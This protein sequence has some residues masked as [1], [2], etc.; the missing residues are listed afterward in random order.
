MQREKE[1]RANEWKKRGGPSK[2]EEGQ[3]RRQ[4]DE[5]EEIGMAEQRRTAEVERIHKRFKTT[6]E[7]RNDVARRTVRDPCLPA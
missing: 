5:E 1:Q 7:E 2:E 6:V 3:V 4:Q